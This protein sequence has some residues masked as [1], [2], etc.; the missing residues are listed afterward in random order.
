MMPDIERT[1]A[2]TRPIIMAGYSVKPFCICPIIAA[3][4]A[5]QK[6]KAGILI[7]NK[8]HFGKLYFRN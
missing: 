8:I 7:K 1:R 4:K 3:G 2:A 6:I 5:R